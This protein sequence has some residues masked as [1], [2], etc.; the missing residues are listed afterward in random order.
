MPTINEYKKRALNNAGYLG[1]I[2]TA[3]YKW[4]RDICDPYKGAIPDM[5]RYALRRVGFTGSLTDMQRDMLAS[6]GYNTGAIPNR[7]YKYW[8]GT[9]MQGI[10]YNATLYLGEE[11]NGLSIDFTDNSY[12][13]RTSGGAEAY[14]SGLPST[15]EN[16]LAIDFTDDTYAVRS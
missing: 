2:N 1:D 16:G 14:L 13:I 9:P 4:L 3:E 6:L 12:A 11:W 15:P 5:W 10:G 7:W 8:A